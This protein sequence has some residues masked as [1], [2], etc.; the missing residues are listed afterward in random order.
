MQEYE[1]LK[2]QFNRPSFKKILVEKLGDKCA[3]CGSELTVEYHHV[4]ALALGGTNRLTNIVPLCWVCHQKAHGSQN[5]RNIC[6]SENVG[7]NRNQPVEN[8]EQIL[9]DYLHGKIGRKECDKQLKLSKS[10]KLNDMWYFKEYLERNSIASYKNRVDMLQTKRC[11]RKDHKGEM[12]SEIT[13]CDGT[14]ER[15]YVK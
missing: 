4:V 9:F 8:Y 5:I 15:T 10:S 2:I 12:L 14:T 3:N 11:L 6:R 13:F 7:R 1:Q